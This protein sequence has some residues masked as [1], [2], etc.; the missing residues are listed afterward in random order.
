MIIGATRGRGGG[1]LARHL[2]DLRQ[3]NEVTR[4]GA[5]RG[6]IRCGVHDQVEELTEVVAH[7]QH[8]SPLYH[9]HVNPEEDWAEETWAEFWAEFERE[10]GLERQAFTE[11]VHG[12][13]ARTHRHRVYSLVRPDGSCIPMSHDYARH[14]FLARLFELRTGAQPVSGAHNRAVLARCDQEGLFKEAAA[15]CAAGLG[16]GPRRRAPTTPGERA[17]AERTGVAPQAVRNAALRAW[18]A[19]DNTPALMAALHDHGLTLVQGH[20]GPGLL[21][22]RGGFHLLTRALA[23]AS[24][25][26]GLDPIHAAA[27]H[28]RLVN[29]GL[30]QHAPTGSA[31]KLRVH[32]TGDNGATDRRPGN[33]SGSDSEP[34]RLGM[35]QNI[36]PAGDLGEELCTDTKNEGQPGPYRHSIWSAAQRGSACTTAAIDQGRE[37]VCERAEQAADYCRSVDDNRGQPRRNPGWAEESRSG[38]SHHCE[39]AGADRAA[40]ARAETGLSTF[41]PDPANLAALTLGSATHKE[42]ELVRA[43]LESHRVEAILSGMDLS[44]LVSLTT[45]LKHQP[46]VSVTRL[47]PVSSTD[48]QAVPLKKFSAPY[49]ETA[50]FPAAKRRGWLAQTGSHLAGAAQRVWVSLTGHR[51]PEKQGAMLTSA[52]A[53]SRRHAPARLMP[54]QQSNRKSIAAEKELRRYSTPQ[55]SELEALPVK[56]TLWQPASD[57]PPPTGLAGCQPSP[58]AEAVSTTLLDVALE[59]PVMRALQV[60]ASRSVLQRE[61]TKAQPRPAPG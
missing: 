12:K 23:Q 33:A 54:A 51:T 25:C 60:S 27:V 42:A 52:S 44:D 10:F 26:A 47:S 11:V 16:D 4:P 58:N 2:C 37:A 28:G 8:A 45:R 21:D 56:A 46:A 1:K 36:L 14:E 41:A 53:A 49:T 24:R 43:A 15:L 61:K 59:P 40:A 20:S 9:V 38:T 39:A 50:S 55:P 7:A 34:T 5:S 48:R 19:S 32:Q 31:T 18:Q 3:K 13:R 35:E 22:K 57:T 6:L 29:V 30:P 17:Q